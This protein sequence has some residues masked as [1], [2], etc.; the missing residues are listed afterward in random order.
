MAQM[1]EANK[2]NSEFISGFI[3]SGL[4]NYFT[5]ENQFSSHS[6]TV[7]GLLMLVRSQLTIKPNEEELTV[8]RSAVV[9]R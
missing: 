8:V 2:C 7:G 6:I 4:K 9:E 3:I 5:W 1:Q